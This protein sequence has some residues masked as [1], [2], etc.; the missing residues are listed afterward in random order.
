MPKKAK[1]EKMPKK[2]KAEK[3]P[4]KAKAEKTP[5]KAI[6]EKMPKETKADI[7]FL[8]YRRLPIQH[9]VARCENQHGLI[10][11]HTMGTGKTFTG[12][13]FMA[14][15]LSPPFK[16]LVI[17]PA[18]THVEWI[19]T[20]KKVGV[21]TVKDLQFLPLET[22]TVLDF[23]DQPTFKK[24]PEK[25][26]VVVDEA[27]LLINIITDSSIPLRRKVAVQDWLSQCKKLLLLT[28][29]P[30]SSNPRDIS[31]IVNVAA[32]KSVIPTTFVEFQKRYYK[33]NAKKAAIS[34]WFAPILKNSAKILNP[35]WQ[36]YMDAVLLGLAT[37]Y[38]HPLSKA[39]LYHQK[40]D[41]IMDHIRETTKSLITGVNN[42]KLLRPEDINEA[43]DTAAAA[44]LVAS[45]V[46]KVTT[47]IATEQEYTE[48]LN[49]A[50]A[51]GTHADRTPKAGPADLH[52]VYQQI[53][54]I[55]AELQ[56]K[57]ND[58]AHTHI[59]MIEH[60]D[61]SIQLATD[62]F[63]QDTERP[64]ELMMMV[65]VSG[66][67]R[68][69]LVGDILA[70][71]L[72]KKPTANWALLNI[73]FPLLIRGLKI[74]ILIDTYPKFFLLYFSVWLMGLLMKKLEKVKD[75]Y[76]LN[77]KAIVKDIAPY[78]STYNP[79][80]LQNDPDI[81]SHYPRSVEKIMYTRLTSKEMVMVYKVMTNRLSAAE[82]ID[83]GFVASK[84]E[85]DFFRS[86]TEEIF[87]KNYGRLVGGIVADG[88]LPQ[89]FKH[90]FDM[91]RIDPQPTLIYSNFP[92][93]LRNFTTAAK[94]EGFSMEII[95]TE[96]DDVAE[97]DRLIQAA[98]NKNIDFLGLPHF[99]TTG[100]DVPGMRVFHILEPCLDI[101]TYKQLLARVVRYQHSTTETQYTVTTY[102]WVAKGPR[103]TGKFAAFMKFWKQ[104]GYH[105]APWL[106]KSE[107][108]Q[109]LT[110]D[111]IAIEELR[112]ASL[113][114][115]NVQTQ[116]MELTTKESMEMSE[117]LACCIYDPNN[118]CENITC[119]E[120]YKSVLANAKTNE[121]A[122]DA[123]KEKSAAD[124]KKEKS[125]ADA[126]KGKSEADARK[127]KSEAYAR[128]GKS[129]ADAQ[130][131]RKKPRTKTRRQR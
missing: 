14:N 61:E 108:N 116:V 115:N 9:L 62:R 127:G 106:F 77:T 10:L 82:L 59:G 78:I 32:G 76:T 23:V 11:N 35:I 49:E 99:A 4:Q 20:V 69:S 1:A 88:N 117:A 45:T 7:H 44:E 110:P 58:S 114:Y 130:A 92:G 6:A 3:M 125:E 64:A 68:E 107:I 47:R 8:D 18:N 53:T 89:K 43:K 80:L 57:S 15:F 28:G 13:L 54:A 71:V 102:T 72:K 119:Q 42:S 52:N 55:Y 60:H 73:G 63:E 112:K 36:Y 25:F 22:D 120:H 75:F 128:K 81:L 48:D 21:N 113:M 34:G 70:D 118:L 95:P 79:F 84:R 123:K 124:A 24:N 5:K 33:F 41:M 105:R 97:K 104:F 83:Y 85:L 29:T 50:R 93:G 30:F 94:N 67:Q 65:P 39:L 74:L 56:K 86:A 109:T 91:H 2:P 31:Y 26:I 17:G 96:G 87:Y 100:T 51:D 27:H 131:K 122:L 121:G 66:T 111:S 98:R 12:A 40:K 103:A 129:E 37:Q 19:K 101:I 38:L 46:N 16:H 90:I 126:K